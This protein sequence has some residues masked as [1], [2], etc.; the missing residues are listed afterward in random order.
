MWPKNMWKR[1][2]H[3]MQQHKTA[4]GKG[5]PDQYRTI[6]LQ[7]KLSH[8]KITKEKENRANATTDGP[9]MT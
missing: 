4:R 5:T 9:R 7:D 3:L 6:T 8:T 1:I 2:P